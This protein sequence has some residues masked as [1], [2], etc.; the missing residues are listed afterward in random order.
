MVDHRWTY[1][2]QGSLYHQLISCEDY[3][4]NLLKA[5]ENLISL[6]GLDVID[7]GAGTGRIGGLLAGKVRSLHGLDLSAHMLGVA[8]EYLKSVSSSKPILTVSDMR[9]V[10]RP[11][12]TA[13]LIIAGW[14][15]CY[16]VVWDP[17]NWEDNLHQA[18]QE[19]GRLLR[20][21]GSLIIIETLGTG[22]REPVIIEKLA[23]YFNYLDQEGFQ[24]SWVRTDYSFKDLAQGEE[25]AS[26]FFGDEM[27]ANLEVGDRILLPECTGIWHKQIVSH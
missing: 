27:L 13:D 25:L 15:M 12:D 3:Q 20:I 1:Q 6:D 8:L 24:F 17:E 11:A 4:G 9:W 23:E 5:V 10:P 16:L 26:F 21:G 7:L 18:M 19:A 22:V 14:S 2:N